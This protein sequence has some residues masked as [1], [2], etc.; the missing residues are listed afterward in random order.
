[1]E[2]NAE[3]KQALVQVRFEQAIQD[4]EEKFWASIADSY[5]EIESGDLAPGEAVH[6]MMTM[7]RVAAVWLVGNRPDSLMPNELVPPAYYYGEQDGD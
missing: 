4:A 1:M 2:L 5:P 6:L 3:Q 7:K